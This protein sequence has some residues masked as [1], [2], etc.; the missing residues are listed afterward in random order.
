[1]NVDYDVVIIGSGV[2]GLCAGALLAH[3]GYRTLVIEREGR[4]GGRCSTEEIE[5]YKLSTGAVALHRGGSLEN[6]FRKVGAAFDLMDMPH[7]WYRIGSIAGKNYTMPPKGAVAALLE[8]ANSVETQRARL[9]GRMAREVAVAKIMGF[10]GR[11]VRGEERPGDI[12]FRQWLSRYTENEVAHQTFDAIA[13]NVTSFHTHE[14]TASEMFALFAKMG[15]YPALG[16]APY[17]NEA[18]L[19][20]LGDVIRAHEGEIWMECSA[21][22]IVVRDGLAEGVVFERE[23]K[24][25]E[26][27]CRAVISDIGPR[28]TVRLAGEEHFPESYLGLIGNLV[29]V[30]MILVHV[31]ADAPLCLENG[32]RGGAL[33]VGMRRLTSAFPLTNFSPAL[34]PPGK[35]LLYAVGSPPSY[36]E[37]VDVAEELEQTTLDLKAQFPEFS[38]S[39]KILKFEVVFQDLPRPGSPRVPVYTPLPNLF[40]VGDGVQ[41]LGSGGTSAAA[42]SAEAVAGLIRKQIKP[43]AG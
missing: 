35:H 10:F 4:V 33:L 42:E 2:G 17:G 9:L 25:G 43:L 28:G 3:D 26:I 23:G 14:I 5:G 1:M 32:E 31:G 24:A 11:G 7:Q 19:R 36:R 22:K 20:P 16:I 30:G 15:T 41:K 29:P 18:V 38:R 12:T 6:V 8:I 39:G 13:C 34:A 27:A 37:P 21:K 40:N